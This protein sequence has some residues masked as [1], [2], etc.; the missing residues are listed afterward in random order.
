MGDFEASPE[1]S[2]IA[3]MGEAG[4]AGEAGGMGGGRRRGRRHTK[5]RIMY[6]P[7]GRGQ[8]G[9]N[10]QQMLAK[11]NAM[12]RQRAEDVITRNKLT[13]DQ[14]A[15]LYSNTEKDIALRNDSVNMRLS[16]N[17]GPVPP[18]QYK[19]PVPPPPPP[20]YKGPQYKGPVPPPAPPQYKGQSKMLGGATRRKRRISRKSRKHRKRSHR[21]R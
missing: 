19:G 14:A 4:E 2:V 16:Q 11:Q 1:A 17:K 18:P 9:G 7:R 8:Q 21:R 20:Q 6:H 13:P 12:M 10:I 3:S 5:R 15:K